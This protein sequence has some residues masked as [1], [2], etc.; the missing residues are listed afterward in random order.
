M[1]RLR[2]A[3]GGRREEGE[4]G[5]ERGGSLRVYGFVQSVTVRSR[6]RSS[7]ENIAVFLFFCHREDKKTKRHTDMSHACYNVCGGGGR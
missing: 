4:E 5:G 2:G 3:G 6:S 1:G 7:V